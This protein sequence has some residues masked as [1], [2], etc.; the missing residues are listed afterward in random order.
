MTAGFSEYPIPKS[1]LVAGAV[2]LMIVAGLIHLA[3]VPIHWTHAPIH[4]AFF[5]L[6][7][8]IQIAWGIAFWRQPSMTLYRLGVLLAGALITLW[9]ITHFLPA[10]FEHE[11]GSIDTYG[12]ICKIAEGLGIATLVAIVVTR[13]TSPEMRRS[14]WRMA[15]LLGLAAFVIGW[16]AYGV[17]AVLEPALPGLEATGDHH[18]EQSEYDHGA[19]EHQEES[20]T[21]HQEEAGEEHA[22]DE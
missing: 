19:T 18:Q 10:P 1:G 6:M 2:G 3:I 16:A 11:P 5:V 22:H 9:L 17:G 14:A 12:I 15:A 21:E 4:G 8:L 20:G 7:G 13:T